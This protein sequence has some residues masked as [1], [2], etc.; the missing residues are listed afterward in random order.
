MDVERAE[1][2]FRAKLAEQAELYSE[3]ARIGMEIAKT[4]EELTEEERSLVSVAFKSEIG[5]LRSSWRVLS[6]IETREQQR[7]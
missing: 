4:G 7:G 3:F 2:I 1:R 5:Q 6:S